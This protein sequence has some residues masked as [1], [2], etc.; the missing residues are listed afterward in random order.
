MENT[1]DTYAEILLETPIFTGW[2]KEYLTAFLNQSRYYI[3]SYKADSLIM[4][5]GSECSYLSLLTEGKVN[6][7][8]M[9]DEGKQVIIE[10]MQAP[11]AI[12]P[13][14]LFATES[15]YPVYIQSVT[16]CKIFYIDK[17]QFEELMH[18][19]EVIMKNFIR[20][21]SDKSIFLSKKIN[22]FA[23]QTLKERL[24]SYLKN[25]VEERI[26]QQELANRL[27]VTRP[28]LSRVLSELINEG[29]L[30][31]ENRKI[32]INDKNNRQ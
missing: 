6:A 25:N 22:T 5:Q 20:L 8:L 10:D 14:A 27:G 12:A 30:S 24:V 17:T 32:F 18:K 21:L 9:N 15:R 1:T 31:V 2:K 16:D 13:A 19:E 26:T 28:S 29:T 23:L 11:R 7:L 3:R 4:I